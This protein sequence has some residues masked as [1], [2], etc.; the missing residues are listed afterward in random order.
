MGANVQ[1]SGRIGAPAGLIPRSIHTLSGM[2]EDTQA[3]EPTRLRLCDFIRQRLPDILARWE[4]RVRTL[5]V[6]SPLSAIRLIDHMPEVLERIAAVTETA[7]TGERAS[8]NATPEIH[9]LERL[10]EGFD[11]GAV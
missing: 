10:D 11:L 2:P 1:P 7:Y 5:P 3:G 9:A 4:H 8:M 6:A